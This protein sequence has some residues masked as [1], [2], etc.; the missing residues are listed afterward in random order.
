MTSR[1]TAI[2][3]ILA[4]T[5]CGTP[6]SAA[7]D[8]RQDVGD[9][10]RV[11]DALITALTPGI[12]RTMVRRRPNPGICVARTLG[13]SEVD[14]TGRGLESRLLR[15]LGRE[16]PFASGLRLAAKPPLRLGKTDIDRYVLNAVDLARCDEDR[17]LSLHRV[18]FYEDKAIVRFV[19]GGCP[20][21][22]GYFLL[23]RPEGEGSWRLLA[24][25]AH[26]GPC[27][28]SLEPPEDPA[29]WFHARGSL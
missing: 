24:T 25:V 3:L 1:L 21:S 27:P 29:A 12:Q 10:L 19:M 17:Q 2:L 22:H 13:S 20:G 11:V 15:L 28:F 18:H 9:E 8:R 26:T 16:G 7:F 4:C 6:G 5:G 14:F 23:V